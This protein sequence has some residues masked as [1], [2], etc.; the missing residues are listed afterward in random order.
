[1]KATLDHF[2]ELK[3]EDPDFIYNYTLDEFDRVENLFWV[4]GAARKSYALPYELYGD[5]IFF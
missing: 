3:K 2:E 5:C 4:D 1:M